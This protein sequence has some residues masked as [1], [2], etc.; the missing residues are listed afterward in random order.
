MLLLTYHYLLELTSGLHCLKISPGASTGGGGP[1]NMY[2]SGVILGAAADPAAAATLMPPGAAP[3]AAGPGANPAT[4]A[5]CPNS[6]AK[7]VGPADAG[8][9]LGNCSM[10]S[11]PPAEAAGPKGMAGALAVAS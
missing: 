1:D 8:R 2:P 7:G 6:V 3:P 9:E 10:L 11:V 5:C 4:D